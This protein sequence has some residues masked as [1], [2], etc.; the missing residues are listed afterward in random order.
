MAGPAD[1]MVVVS[2]LLF[3]LVLAIGAATT[4]A[5]PPDPLPADWHVDRSLFQKAYGVIASEKLM[6]PIIMD[7]WPVKID[8]SRQLFVDDYLI[9]SSENVTRQVHEMRKHPANPLVVP[10]KP[11][12][13]S[14]PQKAH[15]AMLM[16]VRRNDKTGRFQMWYAGAA[17]HTL[18]SGVRARYPACYAE[19]DDGIKWTKP[20]LGLFE[21][22]GSKAN[23][24]VDPA[25]FMRSLIFDPSRPD[26]ND[27]DPNRR[28]KAIFRHERKYV[29][30]EG[31]FLCTSPDGIHWKNENVLVAVRT[32]SGDGYT[33]PVT[34]ISD[35]STVRWDSTLGE[36]IGTPRLNMFVLESWRPDLHPTERKPMRVFGMM[37][38]EDLVHWTRPRVS[39]YPDALDGPDA[40][41][42]RHATFEYESMWIGLLGKMQMLRRGRKTTEV[43]LTASRDGRHWSRVAKREPVLP[44]GK[45]DAWDCDYPAPADGPLLVGNDLWFYYWSGPALGS[46][47]SIVQSIG[48]AILRRDGFASLNAGDECGVI[49]TR[50]LDFEG[51]RLHVN[52]T[53]AGGG[54]IRVAVLDEKRKPIAGYSVGGCK[55]ITGDGIDRPVSW[56][57]K[58]DLAGLQNSKVRLRFELRNA[59]LYSFWID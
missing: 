46:K 2:I 42:Y 10:D 31:F 19:S 26:P 8:H 35:G 44:L 56:T 9:G 7:K 11:W 57:G 16:L 34:G 59:K 58:T 1:V 23:N 38:S 50:P 17:Y 53:V 36:Y 37:E 43:Q 51:K 20:E 27:D 45:P 22:E 28:Y 54:E 47:E 30:Q 13:Y 5:A 49:V 21:F 52:A 40:Q 14:K 12:E 33:V 29:P 6:Y 3:V 25:G 4:D 24:I 32:Q 41:I 39:L 48:L 55:A 18:A 15:R